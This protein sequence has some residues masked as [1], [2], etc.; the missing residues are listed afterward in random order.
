M[1]R[2]K[3]VVRTVLVNIRTLTFRVQVRREYYAKPPNI[4]ER[5]CVSIVKRDIRFD[6]NNVC[7]I[8]YT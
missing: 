7:L 8:A 2:R 5:T 4:Y 1:K 6:A 3:T